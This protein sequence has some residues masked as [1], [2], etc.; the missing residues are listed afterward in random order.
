MRGGQPRD[1][2][3]PPFDNDLLLVARRSVTESALLSLGAAGTVSGQ[4][5]RA[6]HN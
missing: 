2:R 4:A 1:F 5:G 3:K 6:N